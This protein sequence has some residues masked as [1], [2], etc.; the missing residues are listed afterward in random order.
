VPKQL[1]DCDR[2]PLLCC[3][4]TMAS[5][6][7]IVL[8]IAAA[9]CGVAADCEVDT[10]GSCRVFSCKADRGPTICQRDSVLG[11]RRCLCQPGYCASDGVCTVPP[12][13]PAPAPAPPPRTPGTPKTEAGD[14]CQK[15][16]D[17]TIRGKSY[18]C[19]S[20]CCTLQSG[21]AAYCRDSTNQLAVC[22]LGEEFMMATPKSWMQQ[23]ITQGTVASFIGCMFIGAMVTMVYFT[24]GKQNHEASSY[25]L[26]S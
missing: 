24:K 15:E 12:A 19:P 1:I 23:N 22:Q 10:G 16:F 9:V 25:A 17:I 11:R 4:R 26:L 13:P 21:G 5:A 6:R 2:S 18:H 14:N 7:F 3:T 20:Y 8:L